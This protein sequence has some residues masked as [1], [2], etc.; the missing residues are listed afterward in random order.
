LGFWRALGNSG[1]RGGGSGCGGTRPEAVVHR[2]RP[3][4]AMRATMFSLSVE[5]SEEL[6]EQRLRRKGAWWSGLDRRGHAR[7]TAPTDLYA[8]QGFRP[9]LART[10][11]PMLRSAA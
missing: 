4:A 5:P 7:G 6:A 2:D 8:R 11:Q 10:E 3:R 9:S 1:G